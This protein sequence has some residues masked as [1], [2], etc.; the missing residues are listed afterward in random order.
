L[1][2]SWISPLLSFSVV[3]VSHNASDKNQDD[4]NGYDGN[5]TDFGRIH[6]MNRP[7][8]NPSANASVIMASFTAWRRLSEGENRIEPAFGLKPLL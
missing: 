5:N 3:D 6:L 4:P 7:F 1:H 2:R 8:R